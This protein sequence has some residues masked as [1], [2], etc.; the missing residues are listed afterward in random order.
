MDMQG[1][2]SSPPFRLL[3]RVFPPSVLTSLWERGGGAPDIIRKSQRSFWRKSPDFVTAVDFF[4]G[5]RFLN[6]CLWI[7]MGGGGV[8]T[9]GRRQPEMEITQNK[10]PQARL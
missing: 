8:V 9:F 10:K 2:L 6:P 3:W 7:Y 1:Q 5:Y 4:L